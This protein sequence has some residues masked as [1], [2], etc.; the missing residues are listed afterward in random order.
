MSK[1]FPPRR[2][3]RDRSHRLRAKGL[4]TNN[5][6]NSPC[7]TA[8][9]STTPATVSNIAG[10]PRG[11]GKRSRSALVCASRVASLEINAG[12]GDEGIVFPGAR[13]SEIVCTYPAAQHTYR[14]VAT[15]CDRLREGKEVGT[16]SNSF[17]PGPRYR[18][19]TVAT[20]CRCRFRRR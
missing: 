11:W 19:A 14:T 4:G 1:H 3:H 15:H 2:R 10:G 9:T 5:N 6:S 18:K 20:H 8:Q 17:H 16:R 12:G 13:N 7:S